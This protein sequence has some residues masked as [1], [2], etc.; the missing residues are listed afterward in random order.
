MDAEALARIRP[1][2]YHTTTPVNFEAIKHWRKLR[3]ARQLLTGTPH[4]HLLDKRR[5][6]TERVIIEGVPVEIRDQ[7]PLQKGHIEFEPDFSFEV[8]L[9][10]L[11]DRVFF[12]PGGADG[13]RERGRAYLRRYASQGKTVVL[14]CLLRELLGLNEDRRSY[15]SA[16][17]S[18]APRSNPKSGYAARG[19]STFQ[20]LNDASFKPVV[21]QEISFRSEAL[22]PA[23]TEWARSFD[24]K[25]RPLWPKG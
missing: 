23:N 13:L 24:R 17:N 2:A 5:L 8:L 7:R 11:N 15:V 6:E 14:R 4:A 1:W 18:G 21:V 16:C 19:W 3:S 22:L 12:W 25:W 9:S 20:L 10:E